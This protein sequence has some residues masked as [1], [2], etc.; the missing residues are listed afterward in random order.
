MLWTEGQELELQRLFEEFQDSDGEPGGL[1]EPLRGEPP[2]LPLPEG[3]LL[4]PFC[5]PALLWCHIC[6]CLFLRIFFSFFN[7]ISYKCTIHCSVI[8]YSH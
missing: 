8:H 4:S 5:P 7:Y 3:G 6:I 1:G 2:L